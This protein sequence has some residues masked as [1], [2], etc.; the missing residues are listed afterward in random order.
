MNGIEFMLIFAFLA[1]SA[2]F[3]YK[4]A[5]VMTMGR[6]YGIT[7]S[8]LGLGIFLLM[9]LITFVLG[10]YEY[11][12]LSVVLVRISSFLLVPL[13]G[14]HFFEIFYTIKEVAVA[15]AERRPIRHDRFSYRSR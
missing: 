6:F 8:W 9:Y 2:L 13:F 1:M 7:F 14:F 5:N 15:N 3:F 12:V 11:T 10:M 4:V